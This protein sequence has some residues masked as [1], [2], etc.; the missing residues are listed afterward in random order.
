MTSGSGGGLRVMIEPGPEIVLGDIASHLR[1]L[2]K[3]FALVGGMA[4]SLRGEV[5]FTRDVDLAIAAPDDTDMERVIYSLRDAG[6][7][8]IAVVEHKERKRLST[9]RLGSPSGIVVDLLAASSGIE[10]EV[11]A[12]ATAISFGDIGAIPVARAEELLAMKVLSMTEQRLQDRIDAINLILLNE[13][14]DIAAVKANLALITERG[15]HRDQDLFTKLDAVLA[16]AAA[17]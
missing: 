9:V 11:V 10:A 14:L 17:G 1:R 16:S 8:P 5:R 12:R 4:V 6:Y 15:F 3:P 7:V 2:G 13:G